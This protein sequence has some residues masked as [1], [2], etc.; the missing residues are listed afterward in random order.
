MAVESLV[1]DWLNENEDRAFPLLETGNKTADTSYVLSDNVIVDALLNF[2]G[3]TITDTINLLT[4]VHS[5]GNVTFTFTG[6][7]NVFTVAD[8]ITDY[9]YVRNSNG[10]LLVVGPAVSTI[11]N[12]THTFTGLG[13][14]PALCIE[15]SGAWLGVSSIAVSPKY[16]TVDVDSFRPVL[17]LSADTTTSPLVG[18]IIFAEGFDFGIKFSGQ[19]IA[20]NVGA[21]QGIPL[22]C[23]DEFVSSEQKDCEDII[24][25]I[26]GIGPNSDGIL[27]LFPGT[28]IDIFM[29]PSS[30]PFYDP[31]DTGVLANLHSLFVGFDFQETD[32]CA[33]VNIYPPNN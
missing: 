27:T 6:S 4:I 19:T 7:G 15:M 11:P 21:S 29:L 13:V 18:D 3:G 31:Y 12:G 26:N 9:T 8:N 20:L 16:D 30:S 2:S 1:V 10:S 14:E 32:L 24:S 17:P 23:T 25:Y 5:G 28:D 22:S 33:P